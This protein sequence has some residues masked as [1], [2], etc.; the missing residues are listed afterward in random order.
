MA[1]HREGALVMGT[2]PSAI[3]TPVERTT[4]YTALVA[5]PDGIKAQQ[6]RPHLTVRSSAS[7]RNYDVP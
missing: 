5:L 4:R 7:R 3:G 2:R 6:V 1:G